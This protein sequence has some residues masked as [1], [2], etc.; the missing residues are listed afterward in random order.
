MLSTKH[1]TDNDISFFAFM[2]FLWMNL[3]YKNVWRLH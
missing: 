3:N 1:F 2:G